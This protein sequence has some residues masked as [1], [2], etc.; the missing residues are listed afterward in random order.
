MSRFAL[1]AASS[2]EGDGT[3]GNLK[4]F[5][6]AGQ[7]RSTITTTFGAA[8]CWRSSCCAAPPAATPA[9][10][11]TTHAATRPVIASRLAS[12]HHGD[13][14]D[15]DEDDGETHPEPGACQQPAGAV[16]CRAY[17]RR[18]SGGRRR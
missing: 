10:E 4:S 12:L 11:T 13:A 3:R 9:T 15:G 16:G 17:G 18:R 8:C 6:A 2:F 7:L 5:V 14:H 1:V